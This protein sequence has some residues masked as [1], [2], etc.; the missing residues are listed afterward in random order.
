MIVGGEESGA[1]GIK[2]EVV[3]GVSVDEVVRAE[4]GDGGHGGGVGQRAGG[5]GCNDGDDANELSHETL[6]G[7]ESQ[8]LDA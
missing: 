7:S 8:R 6:Y 4:G 2:G 5:K 1:L 3:H